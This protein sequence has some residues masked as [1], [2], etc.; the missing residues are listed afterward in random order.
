[1]FTTLRNTIAPACLAATI[2]A[3]PAMAESS[4]VM[5][6]YGEYK[7]PDGDI[8][9]VAF[10]ATGRPGMIRVC[11][12]TVGKVTW[13]KSAEVFGNTGWPL[14]R[15][16]TQDGNHGPNCTEIATSQFDPNNTRILLL[17]AKGLGAHT[18]I[19]SFVFRPADYDGKSINFKWKKD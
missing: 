12:T 1:M 17:K 5:P 15:V 8:L 4:Q 9:D 2:L 14:G 16:E 18:G 19:V 7:S 11:L 6:P 3:A 13:W 10:P